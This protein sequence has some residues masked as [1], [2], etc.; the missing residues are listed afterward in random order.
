VVIEICIKYPRGPTLKN[1]T[2]VLEGDIASATVI[3]VGLP[4]H[5]THISVTTPIVSAS[6][7]YSEVKRPL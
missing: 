3:R 5:F 7:N 1:A 6:K 4:G 2:D